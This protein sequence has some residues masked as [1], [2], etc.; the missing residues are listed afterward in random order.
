MNV[1][2]DSDDVQYS[3]EMTKLELVADSGNTVQRG[4]CPTCGSQMYSRTIT[5]PKVPIRV[6]AGTLD[7]PNIATPES[8]IWGPS[9]PD[10][11]PFPEGMPVHVAGPGS[12]LIGSAD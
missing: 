2:F 7:D 6:R 11:A 1:L 3:G 4:F 9:A 5:G 12:E 10:W 8:I